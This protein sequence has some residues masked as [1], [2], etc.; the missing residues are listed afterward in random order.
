MTLMVQILAGNARKVSAVRFER[1]SQDDAADLEA[2]GLTRL[3]TKIMKKKWGGL[4]DSEKKKKKGSEDEVE[5]NEVAQDH[6]RTD[7]FVITE[8]VDNNHDDHYESKQ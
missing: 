5:A 1:V 7:D 4:D 8:H 6:L 3:V 2:K